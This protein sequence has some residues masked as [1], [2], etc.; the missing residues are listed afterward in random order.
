MKQKGTQKE[1]PEMRFPLKVLLGIEI[2]R[3]HSDL[4]WFSKLKYAELPLI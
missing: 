1:V 2:H 3:L 4:L